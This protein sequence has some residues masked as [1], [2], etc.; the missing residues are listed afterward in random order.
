MKIN[1]ILLE[2]HAFK[3]GDYTVTHFSNEDDPGGVYIVSHKGREIGKHTY[4]HSFREQGPSFEAAKKQAIA[5]DASDR[6]EQAVKDKHRHQ[7]ETPLSEIE[8]EWLQ[9]DKK[10]HSEAKS[11]TYSLTDK[12]LKRYKQLGQIVRMSIIDGTHPDAS[13]RK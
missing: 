1:E 8:K 3:R 7:Y 12:D 10:M 9:L 11:K 5:A 4:K 13:Y 2:D 6:K